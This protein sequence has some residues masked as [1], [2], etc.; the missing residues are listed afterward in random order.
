MKKSDLKASLDMVSPTEFQKERMFQSAI[1]GRLKRV[2]Y[3]KVGFVFVPLLVTGF[4]LSQRP[5]QSEEISNSIA[6][7]FIE[8]I[9]I[10]GYS[11]QETL[12]N[13]L[14]DAKDRFEVE[15]KYYVE[16]DLVVDDEK[17]GSYL[18][19][20]ESSNEM[21]N[22]A[23]IYKYEDNYV[24]VQRGDEYTLFIVY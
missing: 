3:W 12:F 9:V 11:H 22:R 10:D 17:I 18:F 13:D 5:P 6:D 16:T 4:F 2:A 14:I 24:A 20:L 15:G 7:Q 21:V 19:T 23:I 8:V 1:H